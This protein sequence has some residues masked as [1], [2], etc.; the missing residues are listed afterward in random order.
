MK[1]KSMKILRQVFIEGF[2]NVADDILGVRTSE[3]AFCIYENEIPHAWQ[4]LGKRMR[5][6]IPTYIEYNEGIKGNN[7]I[8]K[9][10]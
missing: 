1:D 4:R 9:L 8:R 3:G 2:G 10:K 5:L 6:K 7:F